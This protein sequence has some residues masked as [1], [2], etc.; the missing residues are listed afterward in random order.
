M[1]KRHS[2][3]AVVTV[4]ALALLT[5]ACGTANDGESTEGGKG[6]VKMGMALS[7]LN[8]FFVQFKKGAEEEAKAHG[9]SLNIQNARDDASEQTNQVQNL[10]AQDIKALII[11]PVDS[12]A[13]VPSVKSAKNADIPVV[14]ADRSIDSPDV[15]TT[16]ASDNVGGGKLA[17]KQMADMLD[18]KGKI[19]VLR[20]QTGTSA[21][22]ER[23]KGF[24][25]GIKKFPGIKVAAKQPADFLR[26]KGM[27]VTTNLLQSHPDIDGVFAENDEMALGAVKALRGRAGNDVKVIGFDGTPEAIKAVK[28]GS[29]SCTIAQQ[30]DELGKMS[31]RN[32]MRIVEDES[33][34]KNIKVPVKAVHQKNVDD[35]S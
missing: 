26:D 12:K 27:D 23:G 13:A 14:A 2:T 30:P 17:A 34:D 31:V 6:K 22:R 11:N 8:P 29:M 1:S 15:K 9:V 18:G 19:I 10:T 20:G 21:S 5:S 32:A 24:E 4:A 35:F 25:E 7:A 28:K 16:V 33:V 3:S